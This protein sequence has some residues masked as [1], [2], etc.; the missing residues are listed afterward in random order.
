MCSLDASLAELVKRGA[1]AR[2]EALK[3]CDDPARFGAG[4]A[5]AAGAATPA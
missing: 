1:V 3:H 4:A 5:T 2:D